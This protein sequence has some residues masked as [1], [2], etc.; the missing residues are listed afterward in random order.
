MIGAGGTGG[1]IYPALAVVEALYRQH[2]DAH[3]VTFI[4]SADG[5][6]RPL[7][8]Q[9]GVTFAAYA[10]VQAGPL[11]GVGAAR[12]LV[13]AG[14]MAVG[15]VQALR[16]VLRHRPQC[17][18]LTGGWA[19]VP[20]AL[21]ANLLR[22][23]ILIF[24]PDIE[25]GRT[26]QLLARLPSHIALTVSDSARYFPG[27][28][29]TVTG[30]PLRESVLN[31]TREAGLWHFGLRDDAP[32][33]LV[34]GGSRGARSINQ[35]VEAVLPD[36]LAD[37]WQIIHITGTLDAGRSAEAVAAYA[38][39]P[40][41]RAFAYLHADMGLAMAAA[42]LVVCRA[43]ASTLGEL[44]HFGL[45]AVLVPY[46]HAWQYQKTNADYL[47]TRGAAVRLDDDR[48]LAELLPLIRKLRANQVQLEM[49]KGNARRLAT[50]GAQNL[51]NLLLSLAGEGA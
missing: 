40:G 24:L 41:Y 26:I 16:L 13:S 44:P 29:A 21:A 46:P 5:F 4:G 35:T 50:N 32:V 17:L 28:Q 7:I 49:M 48:L 27:K 18:L 6:E 14:R 45:P 31:A 19:N 22:V 47:T 20:L 42:D 38:G 33:L 3:N 2:P 39:H 43:G 10:E 25:P 15:F 34:F 30:Y 8:Q 12:A 11:N 9:S 1:H 37:G 51:A 23:P 36:L